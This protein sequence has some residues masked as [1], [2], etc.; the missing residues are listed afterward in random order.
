MGSRAEWVKGGLKV[1]ACIALS[2]ECCFPNGTVYTTMYEMHMCKSIHVSLF[3]PSSFGK[4]RI[5]T[6][7]NSFY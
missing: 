4:V 3:S 7:Q 5:K 6:L 2:A 1:I